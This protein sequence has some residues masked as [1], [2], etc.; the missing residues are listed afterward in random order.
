MARRP[1]AR[2]AALIEVMISALILLV[3]TVGFVGAVKEAMSATAVAHRRTEATLLRTG[4]LEKLA[5]A[6]K[7]AIARL[8]DQVWRVESCYDKDAIPT[9]EN[10][11][12]TTDYACPAGTTYRRLLAVVPVPAISGIDQRTWTVRVLVDRAD[13]TCDAATR[14]SS[15]SCVGADFFVTD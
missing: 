6:P 2:G 4:L 15:I 12:W 9:G 3:V 1:R 13:A 5:V 14:Y 7:A 11:A 8:E 10:T